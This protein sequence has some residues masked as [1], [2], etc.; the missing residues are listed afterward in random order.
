MKVG[1]EDVT[2]KQSSAGASFNVTVTANVTATTNVTASANVTAFQGELRGG[3]HTKG[4]E[5]WDS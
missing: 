3:N 1:K 4:S 5:I 2:T